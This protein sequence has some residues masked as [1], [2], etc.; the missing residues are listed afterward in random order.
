MTRLT[1]GVA[2]FAF[3]YP[4]SG[5]ACAFYAY[6]SSAQ[7]II[8]S[9]VTLTLGRDT[10]LSLNVS[11]GGGFNHTVH[12]VFSCKDVQLRGAETQIML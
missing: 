3:A 6:V 11:K 5:E 4:A 1:D 10:V 8:S 12:G 9:P 2:S 7:K